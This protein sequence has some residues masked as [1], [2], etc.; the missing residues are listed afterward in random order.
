MRK[1]FIATLAVLTM[2][3]IART[4]PAAPHMT[5]VSFVAISGSGVT[6][7]V[8]VHP[9]GHGDAMFNL[10]ANGLVPS[11]IYT[12]FTDP[13][14]DCAGASH[15]LGTF[16]SDARGEGRLHGK[17]VGG[18]NLVGT[19]ALRLGTDI[20]GTLVACAGT[21][22]VSTGP[23][24]VA[25]TPAD[26]AIGV[27]L[28]VE[29]TA[30]FSAAMDLATINSSTFTLQHG[31]TSVTG[32]VAYD[33]ATRIATFTPASALDPSTLYTATVTTGA[34]DLA[35]KG[36]AADFTWSFT[37][38]SSPVGQGPLD[39]ASAASFVVLAGST[40]TNTGPSAVNGDLGLSPGTAVTGFPPG[41][42]NGVMHI[43]D[44]TAAQ[45]QLDMMAAY[46][47]GRQRTTGALR[48]DGNIGGRTL[49][50]GLY[51]AQTS[52]EISTGDLTLDGQGD[53][54]AVFLFQVATTLTTSSARNVLLANGARAA[55]V[56]WLVGS[57]A[58][59]GTGSVFKG[60]IL[61]RTSIT[62][63]TG[64]HVDGRMFAHTGAVTLDND[65]I[66]LPLAIDPNAPTVTF[67]VPGNGDTG[68]PVTEKL[69]ASFS[70]PMDPATINTSTFTV[71]N[72]ATAV[73]GTVSYTGVTATFTPA[74]LL[75]PLTTYTA[76]ITTGA[77]D[78]GGTPLAFG[79]AWNFTTGSSPDLTRPV[80]IA[81]VP[82]VGATGVAV[83]Q[84]VTAA[85]SEAMDPATIN[86][87]NFTLMQ[88]T[89][90]VAGT[91]SYA[92]VTATFTPASNL[93]P[94]TPYTATLLTGSQDL[95]GNGLLNNFT[96]TFTTGSGVD[97]TR[98]IVVA[99][100]P[101]A[102]AIAVG[103]NQSVNVTFS[104]AMDPLSITTG[105]MTLLGPGGT[106]VFGTASYDVASRIATFNPTSP[107]AANSG[108]T[109]TVSTGVKDLAGNA[110]AT[111]FTWTFT[112][113][114]SPYGQ[115]PLALG[116]AASYY[117][118]GGST[119]TN[120]GPTA[121]NGDLGLS[122][123]TAITGFPPGIVNGVT[124]AGDPAAAQAQ[125]DLV[126]AYNEARLREIGAIRLDGNIGG[127]TLTP[128]L[129]IGQTSLEI[130]TGDL[131]L[132]ALG[133]A[134]AVFVFQVA[135]TLTTASARN[136]LL[137][138]GARASNVYWLVGSSATIGTGSVFEGSILAW[139]SITV[140]TGAHVNGRMLAH[141]GAVTL[142]T[143]VVGPEPISGAAAIARA[144]S[145]RETNATA[146]VTN[147]VSLKSNPIV[148]GPATI[149]FGLARADQVEINIYNVAGRMVRSLVSGAY[150]S[151]P[152][153]AVWDRLDSNGRS[154]PRGVY[155]TRAIYAG[156]R[157]MAT[158]RLMIIE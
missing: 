23:S 29:P 69:A 117:V 45:A 116:S 17:L 7:T 130:S 110:L 158:N 67:T 87:A 21:G 20:G 145:V 4:V 140:T 54:N 40:V 122:P 39:L 92:G 148:S 34:K 91:V 155:F 104:E 37:T 53:P 120:T 57:S 103:V 30:T 156:Q 90:V 137:V 42:V 44:A 147:S 99:T 131:T 19:V 135:T 115:K 52:L 154:V 50:P 105:T 149:R 109:A 128:G 59:I 51:I 76:R 98:P 138:N 111:N 101:A 15:L 102:S 81:I 28:G 94:M 61:A 85:F 55:N 143:D 62:V 112:T 3:G 114:N 72:G 10:Q 124:N 132:D 134:N 127:R 96:W 113:G 150:A 24:V 152:H 83:N 27:P 142:D 123:G 108:F 22:G 151:G 11:M 38:G 125:L 74:V 49:T 35:G 65:V 157:F 153:E 139:V 43:A 1:L 82:T 79:F 16:T 126:A 75:A 64:A 119:V 32:T 118:L 89:T 100:V 133:D 141:T 13:A 56:Y 93:A 80:V 63:T 9:T 14:D 73:A 88:G 129:Y 107:L 12:A 6:G 68:A 66:G 47:E 71:M 36:I 33:Q 106:T 2:L 8:L 18:T 97:A 144:S 58:T 48:L 86:A 60:N 95:A 5:R 46:D 121:I 41:I 146:G 31:V 25:T 78:L 77:K 70:K 26:G 136:V 84:S